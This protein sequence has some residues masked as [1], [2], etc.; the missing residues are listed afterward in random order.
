MRRQAEWYVDHRIEYLSNR[1]NKLREM[2]EAQNG[3]LH[4][5]ALKEFLETRGRLKELENIR[6]HMDD[7]I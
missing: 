6:Q 1:L 3:Q 5:D 2:L 7:W 4:Y